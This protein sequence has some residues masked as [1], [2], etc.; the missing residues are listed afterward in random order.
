MFRWISPRRCRCR[1]GA[2][3][4]RPGALAGGEHQHA[5]SRAAMEPGLVG[6]EHS[7]PPT[8]PTG[9]LPSRNGARPCRPGA[10]PHGRA[11]RVLA[12]AAM[13]PGLVGR[14]HRGKGLRWKGLRGAAMEPGLVGREHL[15]ATLRRRQRSR[16]RNGAR[17]CRP[18]APAQENMPLVASGR[19]QWSPALSA[20]STWWHR[21][22]ERGSS[23][24]NGARPCRPG[25]LA[26]SSSGNSPASEPQ[27]SPA[28]SAGSTAHPRARR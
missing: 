26:V 23:G 14:E 11:V 24:R 2:R 17:P 7:T 5:A 4:S 13:E 16:G 3:P 25:A 8:R 20:G 22:A 15:L 18:G 6:R 1:N 27:W 28:L 9:E 19:P 12:Q 21:G 10:H